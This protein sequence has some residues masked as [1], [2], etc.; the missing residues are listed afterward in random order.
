MASDNYSHL[1][2][3]SYCCAALNLRL[4]LYQT[5]AIVAIAKK[6]KPNRYIIPSFKPKRC[7]ASFWA[8][9]A[10]ALHIGHC[11]MATESEKPQNKANNNSFA[12]V[13]GGSGTGEAITAN[14]F[15]GVRAVV[16]NSDNLE[17]IKLGRMHND[18]NVISFGARFVDFDFAKQAI[19][20][21][22]ET[23]FEGGRHQ[24][25]INKIDSNL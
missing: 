3:G 1:K 18:A 2:N 7:P 11:A 4:F 19:K 12:I 24:E 5:K 8:D 20:I 22:L 15:K 9:M 17:I 10:V 23:K 21:F 25:R 13:I 16:A 14:R 6:G